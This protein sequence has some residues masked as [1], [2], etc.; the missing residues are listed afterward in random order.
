M[1]DFSLPRSGYHDSIEGLSLR[2][3]GCPRVMV[4]VLDC[5]IVV[6]LNSSCA[7]TFIFV[8]IPLG[9]V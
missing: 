1:F 8:Q 5:G 9:K 7:I 3:G 4:K 2:G 6:S